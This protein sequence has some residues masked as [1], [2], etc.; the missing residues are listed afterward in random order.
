MRHRV[1]LCELST[2]L[3]ISLQVPYSCFSNTTKAPF[4]MELTRTQLQEITELFEDTAEYYCDSNVISGQKLW[5][6]LECLATAKLAELN[7][8][9]G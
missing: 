8:E 3:N 2:K 4:F 1:P 9:I 6:V 7:G 5:T